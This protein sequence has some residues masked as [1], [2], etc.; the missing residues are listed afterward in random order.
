MIRKTKQTNEESDKNIEDSSYLR[1]FVRV[2][3]TNRLLKVLPLMLVLFFLNVGAKCP[4]RSSDSPIEIVSESKIVK[5][6]TIVRQR[7]HERLV[8]DVKAYITKMAP[9]SKLSAETLVTLCQEYNMDITFVLSQALVESHF[10]TKGMAAQTN[11]VFNVGTW[12]GKKVM[13]RYKTQNESIEPFLELLKN[14]YLAKRTL[15][16]LLY[17]G[18]YV[19]HNGHRYASSPYYERNLRTAMVNIG[20]ET[21]IKMYQD[22]INLSDEDIVAYFGTPN[23]NTTVFNTKLVASLN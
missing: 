2:I 15:K 12:D 23:E 3:K 13:C 18:G 11:S 6:P 22:V 16:Q 5:Y 4:T 7:I 14:D 1:S 8:K 9:T 19:N 21:S 10:G 17:D 20:M